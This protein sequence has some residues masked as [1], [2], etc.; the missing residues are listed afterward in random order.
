LGGNAEEGQKGEDGPIRNKE[1]N[2]RIRRTKEEFVE[3]KTPNQTPLSP[4]PIILFY[5]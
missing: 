2:G 1:E 3:K 4:H 5:F